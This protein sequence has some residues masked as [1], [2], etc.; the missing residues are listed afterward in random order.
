MTSGN[1]VNVST[2]YSNFKFQIAKFKYRLYLC[3]VVQ[4]ETVDSIHLPMPYL[5][6]GDIRS[7]ITTGNPSLIV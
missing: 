6:R 5:G 7:M 4:A 2:T 1:P 3:D